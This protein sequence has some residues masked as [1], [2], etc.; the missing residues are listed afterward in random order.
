MAAGTDSLSLLLDRSSPESHPLFSFNWTCES[1]SSP[2]PDIFIDSNFVESLDIPF[3]NTSIG[4]GWFGNASFSYFPDFSNIS[5]ISIT[6]VE[7]SSCSIMKALWDWKRLV[8]DFDGKDSTGA[9]KLPK[10]YK[11]TAII[12]LQAVNGVDVMEVKFEGIWP[13]ETSAL[14]L[15]YSSSDLVKITQQF[16]VDSQKVTFKDVTLASTRSNARNTNTSR[17]STPVTSTPFTNRSLGETFLERGK[18]KIR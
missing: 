4:Q 15:N 9:Y 16:S 10:A 13:A 5:D 3:C 1:I 14:S 6:F 8:C 17:T 2:D 7:N 11:G 18:M 12:K